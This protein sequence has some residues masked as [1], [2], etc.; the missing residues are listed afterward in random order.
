[1]GLQSDKTKVKPYKFGELVPSSSD[2][3]GEP[4]VV[5]PF[6]MK[7]LK[8][9]AQFKNNISDEVIRNERK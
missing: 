2:E 4:N 7:S 9:A 8:D 1:M 6:E 5:K 3:T